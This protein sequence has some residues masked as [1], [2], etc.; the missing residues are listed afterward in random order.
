MPGCAKLSTIDATRSAAGL[1][2]RALPV[3][4][5]WP[6]KRSLL[7]ST[8]AEAT[9]ESG[10]VL[11]VTHT[12]PDAIMLVDFPGRRVV[13]GD[14]ATQA[15]SNMQLRISSDSANRFWQRKLNFTMAM[16][17]CKAKLN[18]KRSV[19]V[20]L[21][22]LTKTLTAEYLSLIMESGRHDLLVD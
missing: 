21:L 5:K 11:L 4:H 17:Q 16:V 20:K 12:N 9:K 22:P 18:G 10:I 7:D 14:A 13:T 8:F 1:L 3:C 19:A 6:A 2:Y 15:A